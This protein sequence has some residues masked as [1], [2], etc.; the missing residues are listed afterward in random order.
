LVI[1]SRTKPGMAF[2]ATVVVVM[3]LLYPV[4]F[5][6]ACWI[7]SRCD[8]GAQ[9]VTVFYRP[10][11]RLWQL[12]PRG[13]GGLVPRYAIVLAKDGWDLKYSPDDDAFRWEYSI[14]GRD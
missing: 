10:F 13:L 1:S 9:F 3:G 2:W 7:T 12:G 4:S 5:G 6:P 11:L 14:I 8:H